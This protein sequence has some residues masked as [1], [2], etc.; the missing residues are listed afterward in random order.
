MKTTLSAVSALG[1]AMLAAVANVPAR[2]EISQ[3]EQLRQAQ[4]AYKQ[5]AQDHEA[6]ADELQ[7]MHDAAVAIRDTVEEFFEAIGTP[8]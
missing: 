5:S 1:L 6:V 2:A 3:E 4:E 7:V 8:E